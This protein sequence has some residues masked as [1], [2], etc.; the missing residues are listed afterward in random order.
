MHQGTYQNK[1][2]VQVLSFN[3]ICQFLILFTFLFFYFI[4]LNYQVLLGSGKY[5]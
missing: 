5:W 1:A 4:I 3:L 2:L